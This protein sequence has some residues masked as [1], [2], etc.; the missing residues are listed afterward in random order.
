LAFVIPTKD[1]REP[2]DRL[3][4]SLKAQSEPCGRVIVV[5]SGRCGREVV[6]RHEGSL[7][8]DYL[9]CHPPGQIRQRN[10]GIAALRAEDRLIGFLDDDIVLYPDALANMI[11][12]WNTCDP[13]T[14]GVGFNI[15]N[16]LPHVS[17]SRLV[18]LTARS[19]KPGSVLPSG[20]CV[21]WINI[22]KDIRTQWLGGG[23]TVWRHA[24]VKAYPQRE[25][26]TRWAVGE[27]LRH[28]YPIGKRYPLYACAGAR[29][30][31]EHVYDQSPPR[32]VH[33]Y[34]GDKSSV[35]LLY[36]TASYPEL[37]RLA[38]VA[39]ILRSALSRLGFAAV[40]ADRGLTHMALG[41]LHGLVRGLRLLAR[42]VS[43]ESALADEPARGR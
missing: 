41:Q 9:P 11:R 31:H 17:G 10:A 35:A 6:G 13:R 20:L 23:Y 30:R 38:C 21:P 14:A 39:T 1:R 18:S 36:F 19:A 12:F 22:K 27:D 37:S 32:T 33:R 4:A 40:T 34:Q 5:D 16:A 8:I 25:L 3:L 42:R 7:P 2:L 28:S 29:V 24:I 26:K 15:V 43:M